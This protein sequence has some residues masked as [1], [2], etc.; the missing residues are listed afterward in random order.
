MTKG[1]SRFRRAVIRTQRATRR[2]ATPRSDTP[3]AKAG[4]PAGTHVDAATASRS[5][6]D[7]PIVGIG[8]SAGGLD[9][10]A[11]LLSA[12]PVNTPLAL[13][14]VQHLDPTHETPWLPCSPGRPACRSSK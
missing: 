2:P 6:I 9:A 12:V 1:A 8:A 14:L 10:F 7:F 4:A 11:E 3:I 5:S 13:V